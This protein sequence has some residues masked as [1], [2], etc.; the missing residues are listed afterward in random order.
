MHE[1]HWVQ[2][3]GQQAMWHS[4]NLWAAGAAGI[5]LHLGIVL[6]AT[7]HRLI[8]FSEAQHDDCAWVT[9]WTCQYRTVQVNR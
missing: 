8:W 5:L 7:R 1:H 6:N 2:G 3:V 9:D 4:E